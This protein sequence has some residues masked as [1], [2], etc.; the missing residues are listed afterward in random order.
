[1]HIY[2]GF[3][4][5]IHDPRFSV[6]TTVDVTEEPIT[7]AQACAQV[8]QEV[9]N[10]DTVIG[11]LIPV[12]RKY[13]ENI[14]GQCLCLRTAEIAY[15]TFP[16]PFGEMVM[17]FGPLNS[18]TSIT[19]RDFTNTLQTMDASQYL[20]DTHSVLGAA[21]LPLFN[22]WPWQVA[23]SHSVKFTCVFGYGSVVSGLIPEPLIHAVKMALENLY[24]NRGPNIMGLQPF[25]IPHTLDAIM[26]QYRTSWI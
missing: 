20:V 22:Y 17:P 14:T 9:G 4:D 1:M 11:D 7:L 23:Q 19:W 24:E 5:R 3:R 25:T 18:I 13:V 26:A 21:Y 16:F 15:D 10:D 6:N 8:R 12:A 2:Y